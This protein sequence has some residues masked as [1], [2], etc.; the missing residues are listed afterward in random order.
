MAIDKKWIVK[1]PGNPAI[2]RQLASDL[3]IDMAL[4]NLFN[5]LVQRNIKTF[6]EAKSF[7]RPKLE[8]LHDPFLIKDMDKAVARLDIA[9]TNSEKILVYGDYDV[10]GTT[11]VALVFSF[12]RSLLHSIVALK[13]SKR[14]HMPNLWELNS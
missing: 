7:F 10:D 12:L 11:A 9:L 6:A 1:Q 5:L 2:V 8:E 13:L 4:S 3:A 14:F